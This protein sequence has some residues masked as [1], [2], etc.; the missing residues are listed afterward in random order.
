VSSQKVFSNNHVCGDVDGFA[1]QI[2]ELNH[3]CL[4]LGI[5]VLVTVDIVTVFAVIV[6]VVVVITLTSV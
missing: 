6:P 3:T 4:D 2:G 1:F 5:T